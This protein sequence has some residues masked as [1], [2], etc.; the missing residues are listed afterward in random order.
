M[1]VKSRSAMGLFLMALLC[2]FSYC[3]YIFF[4]TVVSVCL[5][6]IC[7]RS[8]YALCMYNFATD[9][10]LF[11]Y[12]QSLSLRAGVVTEDVFIIRI[13]NIFLTLLFI[14][15]FMGASVF[16]PNSFLKILSS[17]ALLMWMFDLV[18]TVFSYFKN[19]TDKEWTYVDSIFEGIMWTQNVISIILALFRLITI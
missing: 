14:I 12:E 8:L 3:G 6:Y 5:L 15:Y 11:R 18:K 1:A 4:E 16:A 13:K 9:E 10:A 17:A 2:L 19:Q 7:I